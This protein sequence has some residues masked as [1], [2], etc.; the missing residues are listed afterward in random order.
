VEL[1]LN[2]NVFVLK[3]SKDEM[4]K[5]DNILRS[6]YICEMNTNKRRSDFAGEIDTLYADIVDR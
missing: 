6:V 1:K 3:L 5:L 4:F 2:D